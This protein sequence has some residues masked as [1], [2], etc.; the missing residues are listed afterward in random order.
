MRRALW[1][2]A[3]VLLASC[4]S[5]GGADAGDGGK[6]Q[7]CTA[8]EDCAGGKVCTAQGFC[9]QCQSSGQCRTKELCDPQ[10]TLCRFRDGW[11][12]ACAMNEDCQA[13]SWCR[14]GLCVARDA[15]Q[16][17]PDGTSAQCPQGQRCNTVTTVCEE[18]LGCST[19]GD[20]GAQEVCNV[21]SRQCVARCTAQTQATVCAG[22]EKCV[23]ERCVQCAVNADCGV[24]L[25][26]DPAGRCSSGAR[27]YG[28]RDCKVPLVCFVQT[29]ACL[30]KPP[31][32]VSNDNCP[33][34]LRCDVGTGRC[35]PKTC[36]PDRYEPN[37]APAQATP[38]ATGNYF[39]LTLCPGDVDWYG[40]TLSR[41]DQLGINIDADPFSESTFSALVKDGSG[42]TLAAG[43]LLASYV[44]PA[45]QKYFVVIGTTD[46]FQPYDVTF[47]TSRGTPCDDDANEP[48]DDAASAT[49]FNAATQLDGVICPQDNDWFK[50][51]V[52]A[53]KGLTAS[54]SNYD[55][56][57]GLLRLCALDGATELS[58]DDS[59]S[60]RVLV[61]G[62]AAGSKALL[63]KVSG[64]TGRISNGYTVK[65][66]FP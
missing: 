65:V 4:K 6:A 16:L 40:V 49:T 9:N 29:G 48:N 47:L 51:A 12:A 8:R 20:C 19:D 61:P 53:G 25:T 38:A 2:S 37:D 13:G 35:V 28:D 11:G 45:S 56:G 58:C 22:G 42:R 26:C 55:S 10:T 32:C 17:C 14:Q 15:V 21:G 5:T 52:P 23:A 63:L 64:S 39:N 43:K 18:D 33:T 3:A 46:Q 24:G 50:V 36:Q 7:E 62:A 59:A 41:G 54:L 44:A 1:M 34:D 60:P 30:P 57:K 27:C 66:E 31:P